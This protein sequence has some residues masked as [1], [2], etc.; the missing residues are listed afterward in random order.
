MSTA[1]RSRRRPRSSS[2]ASTPARSSRSTRPSEPLPAETV[3]LVR[4]IPT[5]TG[6]VAAH[7]LGTTLIHEHVF[8]TSPDLDRDLPHP[9]WHEEAAIEAAAAEFERLFDLGIR[10]VVDLTV[11]GLGR[12]V[13]RVAKVA[14]RTRMTLIA[15]TGYYADQV[16]PPALRLTGPGLLVDGPDPLVEL[17]LGDIRRGIAGTSVRAGMIKV[18]SDSAGITPDIARVF[19]AAAIAHRE[20]GTPIT[21]H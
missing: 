3:P 4:R 14:A 21:T 2:S 1:R 6:E 12:D 16:L 19:R 13:A 17:F 18:L 5:F 7:E 8:V 15:A 10:T 9:E 11:P 20:T